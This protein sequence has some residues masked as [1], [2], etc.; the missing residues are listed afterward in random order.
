MR[1]LHT[2][3]TVTITGR[4]VLHVV[5]PIGENPRPLA[6]QRVLLDGREVLIR[7]VETFAVTDD[8]PCLRTERFGVL[9]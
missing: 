9:I 8:A 1:E 2:I 5:E 3:E 7:G 6:G 4:G